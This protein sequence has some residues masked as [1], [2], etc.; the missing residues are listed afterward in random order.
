MRSRCCAAGR[1]FLLGALTFIAV[2]LWGEPNGRAEPGGKLASAAV[3]L[4]NFSIDISQAEQ[5]LPGNTITSI[6]QTPDGYLWVGTFRGAVRFDGVRF[7]TFGSG[8]PGLESEHVTQLFLDHQGGLWLAMEYGQLSRCV[9][10]SPTINL[11][12]LK[13]VGSAQNQRKRDRERL[14]SQRFRPNLHRGYSVVSI[15]P[16]SSGT[17]A[18][19]WLAHRIAVEWNDQIGASR[20]GVFIPRWDARAIINRLAAERIFPG[21]RRQIS[22]NQILATQCLGAKLVTVRILEQQFGPVMVDRV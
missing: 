19:C 2:W 12:S 21:E 14:L 15:C 9:S 17:D 22:A 16:H 11:C 3:A 8:T 13:F 6:A 4:N 20:E 5:G 1:D 10:G 18:A 7:E